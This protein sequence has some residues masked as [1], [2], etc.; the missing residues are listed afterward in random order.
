MVSAVGALVEGAGRLVGQYPA[1][2]REKAREAK[3]AW[4]CSV[5]RARRDFGYRQT[6]PLDAGMSETIDWYRA[7]GWL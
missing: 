4:L 2:N 5:D 1:L 7:N 3:H 6:V